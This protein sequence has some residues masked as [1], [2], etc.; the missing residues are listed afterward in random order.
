[1]TTS[2]YPAQ[3]DAHLEPRGGRLMFSGTVAAPHAPSRTPDTAPRTPAPPS[4]P[5]RSGVGRIVLV[6]TGAL[7][8]LLSLVVA[9]AGSLLLGVDQ[10][11]RDPSG[12]VM[13]GDDYFATDTYALT[14][15]SF[16]IHSDA[17]T[18]MVPETLVGDAKVQVTG[19][20]DEPVFVG[21]ASTDDVAAY[22]EG[23]WHA[24]VVDLET[25]D[26]GDVV[27]VY[28]VSG[29]GAPTSAPGDLDIWVAQASG[30]GTVSL[31]WPADE[32][33]WTLVVMNADGGSA[34]GAHVAVG[35]TLPWLGWASGA[36]LLGAALGMALSLVTLYFGLQ[37][38]R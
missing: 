4:G 34:V 12:F 30:S 8:L 15:E 13:S 14:S 27:P 21:V 31:V 3:V 2:P 38:D 19:T 9:G 28:D 17:P 1:M 32:G 6:V 7:G 22:L 36:L 35:A 20:G 16:T 11:T 25:T 24:E 23:V 33:S 37:V 5:R 18:A 10:A 29:R 26:T